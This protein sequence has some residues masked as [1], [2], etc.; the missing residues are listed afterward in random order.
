MTIASSEAIASQLT[1]NKNEIFIS[2]S[3]RNKEF[4]QRLCQAFSNTGRNVWVDWED[5]PPNADWRQEIYSGIE[6][7]SVLVFVIS[8]PSIESYEC[9]LEIDHAV[10]Y[11]KRLIPI[12]HQDVNPSDVRPELASLN[13][14]FFREADDFDAAFH[15]LIEAI[16]TDLDYLREHTRLLTRAIEWDGKNRSQCYLLRGHDLEDAQK[17]CGESDSKEPQPTLLQSQYVLESSNNKIKNQR[18]TLG[19]VAAGLVAMAGLAFWADIQRRAAIREHVLAL[20]S[21]AES[22]LM[23]KDQLGALVSSVLAAKEAQQ[24]QSLSDD[25]KHRAQT[26]LR[27]AVYDVNEL[28]RL[29]RHRDTVNAI[30]FSSDGELIASA[31][32]DNTVL[33]W[34]SDGSLALEAPLPHDDQVRDVR[35]F[36]DG[37]Q[38]ITASA[39]KTVKIWNVADGQLIQTLEHDSAV[40]TVSVSPDG[41]HLVSGT[42]EGQLNLWNL[43]GEL[44][45]T[46]QHSHGAVNEVNFSPNSQTFVSAGSDRTAKVWNLNGDLLSTLSGHGDHIWSV[47]FSPDGNKIAT[48]SSDDTVRLWTKS[49]ELIRILHGHTNWIMS[50]R[51]SPNGEMIATASDDN[52]V[53]IWS[54]EGTL[55]KTYSGLIGGVKSAQ[56]APD[57]QMLAAGGSD[58]TI[59]LYSLRGALVEVLQGHRSSL[60]GVRFTPD[61]ETIASTGTDETI[62]L[63]NR[64]GTL[65]KILRY[66]DGLRN[67]NISREQTFMITASYDNTMQFWDMGAVFNEVDPTPEHIFEGHTSTVW[68]LSIS[69]NSDLIA[70]ASADGTVRL[71]D[72]DGTL[73][74]TIDAHDPEAIDVSFMREG[75]RFVSVGADGLVKVWDLEGNLLQ[76]LEGHR[77]WINALYHHPDGSMFATA[78]SDKTVIIW[79][80]DEETERFQQ[81]PHHILE[82]HD[83]WV[84]DVAFSADGRLLASSGRDGWINLWSPEDGQRIAT[85]QEHQDWVRAVSFH[86][87]GKTLASASADTT[88][89]LWDLDDIEKLQTNGGADRMHNL[90]AEACTHLENY[91]RTNPNLD[92]HIRQACD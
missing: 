72:L 10:K 2:Y 53:R 24:I 83:D 76:T 37:Q 41:T 34:N 48:A 39:D 33:V 60:N 50:V 26:A 88:M 19:F 31:S 15:T 78:S 42:I 67:V 6:A 61:G 75:D 91:L 51:F 12:L 52:T 74:N 36:S 73:L 23:S 70:S 14:I 40:R 32:D 1:A 25:V 49:G 86:P 89:I 30:A 56:F 58:G 71:W 81:E 45:H 69:P 79:K 21:L 38:L 35:F 82:G 44:L 16:D 59:R 17:L 43:S 13:W 57:N 90:L 66:T 22:Q 77:G 11:N 84:W 7:A 64:D 55:F 28:N 8:P 68:N 62:R 80:W 5:I 54:L 4:V 18:A 92:D 47:H 27:Q 20:T 87:N 63:W 3:R 85:L 9:G 46:L 29:E 65:R